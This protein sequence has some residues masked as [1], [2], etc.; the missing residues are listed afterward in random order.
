MPHSPDHPLRQGPKKKPTL[1]HL[2]PDIDPVVRKVSD[3]LCDVLG[4]DEH[5]TTAEAALVEDLGADS[6]D[7]VEICML[8]EQEFDIDEIDADVA[9]TLIRVR[10]LHDYVRKH[11]RKGVSK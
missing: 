2:Q 11:G 3:I 7:I 1:T 5:D 6:L 8:L 4:V 10:D 9:E